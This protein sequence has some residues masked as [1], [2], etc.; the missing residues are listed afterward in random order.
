MQHTRFAEQKIIP[1]QTQPEAVTEHWVPFSAGL[2]RILKELSTADSSDERRRR[3]VRGVAQVIEEALR[4][5]AAVGAGVTGCG[6]QRCANQPNLLELRVHAS[7][8]L[9]AVNTQSGALSGVDVRAL[10]VPQRTIHK[11]INGA[12]DVR[13]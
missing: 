2:L 1:V 7:D 5:R 3:R 10:R 9:L 6:Q 13:C 8:V 11:Y 12:I 4:V